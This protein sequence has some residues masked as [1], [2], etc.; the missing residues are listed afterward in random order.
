M[1]CSHKHHMHPHGRSPTTLHSL[2]TS[3]LPTRRQ[4]ADG[5]Y[6][7]TGR[8]AHKSKDLSRAWWTDAPLLTSA[9]RTVRRGRGPPSTVEATQK[10]LGSSL[11]GVVQGC[12]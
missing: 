12:H 6:H 1:T 10:N 4:R 3:T 9:A 7:A 5:R 8:G 2:H 11:A